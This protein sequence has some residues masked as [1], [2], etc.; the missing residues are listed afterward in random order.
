MRAVQVVTLDGPGAVRINDVDA[1][2]PKPHEVL[3]DVRA[4]D[5]EA[6]AGERAPRRRRPTVRTVRGTPV[7]RAGSWP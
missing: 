2:T 3:I 1:P 6:W 4:A 7:A 5:G